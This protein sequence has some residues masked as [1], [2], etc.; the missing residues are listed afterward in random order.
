MSLVKVEKLNESRS[1]LNCSD[2][3]I[4]QE[5]NDY[6][7][8]TVKGHQFMPAFK[9]GQW[10]GKIRLF[11]A[12]RGVIPNGLL[13][14]TDDFCKAR[15][16]TFEEEDDRREYP[17]DEDFIN[18]IPLCDAKG[19]KIEFRDYQKAA[20]KEAISRHR[21]ILLSPTASGKSLMIYLLIR[22]FLNEFDDDILLVV[23]T[24]TLV[25]QMKGDFLD[26]AKMDE[27]FDGEELVHT[28]MAGADKTI[29]KRITIT[30]W[31]SAYKQPKSWFDR[32]GMVIG[33]EA[34]TFKAQSLVKIMDNLTNAW[35]RVGTTGTIPDDS[36]VDKL[37]LQAHFGS[38]YEVTTT[39]HLIDAGT[40]AKLSIKTMVL[41]YPDEQRKLVKSA[42]YKMEIDWLVEN[43]RRNSF[44]RRLSLSTKGNTLLLFNFVDKH[45][46]PLYEGLKK[47]A[48]D[49]PIFYV[50]GK[51]KTSEREEIRKI[52][53]THTDAIIVA[54]FATYSTGIN[55]RNLNNIIFASPTKSTIR[56][57]QSIGRGLRKC[58]RG[59]KTTLFD[60]VDDL[61]WKKHQNAAFRHGKARANIYAQQRFRTK[62][63]LYTI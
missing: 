47:M 25:D 10:D 59:L 31:Q 62:T 27:N 39:K 45:G 61:C 53:E 28:I 35:H 9:R 1:R 13:Q 55:I 19:N 34:H 30:T 37:T 50:S 58:D 12:M 7:T 33:D 48:P 20:V 41:K 4:T 46:I 52:V 38:I 26:Y 22:H 15:S 44:I 2:F 17:F 3:G 36:K 16:Y 24:T 32:F 23:P 43:E 51:I 40:L 49:R 42:D 56:V 63:Y 21:S 60:I 5:I 11:D 8:F 6:F 54:S 18:E 29:E 57:L 14:M